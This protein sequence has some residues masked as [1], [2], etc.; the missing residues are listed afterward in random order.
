M[1]DT[2]IRVLFEGWRMLQHSYGQV[3]AFQLIHMYKL[4]GPNGILG[5]KIDFYVIEAEYFCPKWNN[6][7]KLVY[8][9]EYNT[10]LSNFKEYN[11]EDIDLIYRQT[12]PYNIN[13][14]IENQHIPKCIFYTS[15]YSNL[16]G[17]YFTQLRIENVQSALS[18]AEPSS[19]IT[20]P[21]GGVLNEQRCNLVKP[22]EI[23][24]HNE[25][26]TYFLKEV[27]N[28]YFT[29]PSNWSSRGI[30]RYLPD[31]RI[32]NR[33]ITHGVDTS[34]FYK[35]EDLSVRK[36]LR[37]DLNV[38][39]DD[40]LM[41]NIAGAMTTNKGVGLVL[42]A[43]HIIV[44]LMNNKNYK[45][46]IKASEDLYDCKNITK[47]YFE[48]FINNNI[49]STDD[50]D[51]LQNHIIFT[52]KTISYSS[53]NELYNASDLYISPYKAE[54]FGLTMLE[55]LASG[56]NVLV[57][58]TG[59]TKEY[60]EDIFANGGEKFITYVDSTVVMDPQGNCE[61]DIKLHDLVDT[62]L[63]NKTKIKQNK[64]T[65]KYLVMKTYIE[66]EYSWYK[67]GEL[68]YKYFT[69]IIYKK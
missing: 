64:G 17:W 52:D 50:I 59:S 48:A 11:G 1:N 30:Q 68:L 10:I 54:G 55:A 57:P 18:C 27:N 35:I 69:D 33:T 37:R 43:L 61:N 25:Y 29:S 44:N 32:R 53:I 6:T 66:K 42:H 63:K 51:K 16:D 65:D 60:M 9:D 24:N 7:K 38:N 8:T 62:L 56:L 3:L 19:V 12:F 15:E 31:H 5:H 49:M 41:I 28:I 46:I 34:I 14:T 13:V 2:K 21:F 20:A 4:Y 22:E 23:Q 26:I 39:D 45:L 36:Q 58:K 40:V 47:L 67:V